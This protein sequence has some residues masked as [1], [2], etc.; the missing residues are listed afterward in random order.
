MKDQVARGLLI[1][2]WYFEKT[3]LHGTVF[4]C[5]F[6]TLKNDRGHTLTKWLSLEG[7]E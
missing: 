6:I 7:Q 3:W 1:L 5:H 2:F 4:K